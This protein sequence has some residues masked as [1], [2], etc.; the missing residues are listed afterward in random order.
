VVELMMN[1]LNKRRVATSI[2]EFVAV[3]LIA[4]LGF[5]AL[6]HVGASSSPNAATAADAKERFIASCRLWWL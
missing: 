1:E 4:A 2:Q 6:R 3:S 5:A